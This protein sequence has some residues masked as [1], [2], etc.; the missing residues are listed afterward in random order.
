MKKFKIILIL[1]ILGLLYIKAISVNISFKKNGSFI[2]YSYIP[3]TINLHIKTE[4]K[5]SKLWCNGKSIEINNNKKHD[6]FYRGEEEV[7]LHLNMGENSCRGDYI[8]KNIKQKPNFIDFITISILIILPITL[9]LFNLLIYFLD[10]IDLDFKESKREI[11]SSPKLIFLIVFIGILIRIL[12]F[13]KY[14]IMLFQHDWHG[15][16]D[17]IKYLSQNYALPYMPNRGW[18]YP[19]Q[20]LYYIISAILYKI[21]LYIGYSSKEA[22]HYGVGSFALISSSL[23]LIFSAELLNYLTSKSWVKVVA[24]LFL[25]FTPSLVYMSARV[26]NDTLVLS[27]SVMALYFIVQSYREDF[28]KGFYPALTVTTLLF[29]TKLST[30]S[31]EL[32]LFTLLIITYIKRKAIKREL[33]IFSLIGVFILSWTLWHLYTPLN[34]GFYMVN[35]AKFPK[36]TIE[37][38]DSGYFLSFHISNLISQGYSFVFGDNSVRYSLPTYQYGTMFFG[39]FD[40]RYFLNRTPY[41]LD[42]MRAILISGLIYIVGLFSYIAHIKRENL[43]NRLIFGVVVINLILILKFIIS[44]PSICN[45]DF[46]YFVG[47]FTIIGYI[48]AQGLYYISNYHKYIKYIVNSFL[49][50]LIIGELIFFYSLYN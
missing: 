13:N 34:G 39:E 17:L 16:I 36:Q 46:R 45:S 12:Y 21:F 5:K 32:F 6:Y 35:S 8:D 47:S 44:Y 4:Y 50:L 37:H 29:L 23:F 33:L 25:S 43:L 49:L 42:I 30:A 3:Q 40:Y 26:N 7:T 11:Y 41:L 38:L 10:K 31:I 1:F 2:I 20:P 18:E 48:F 27:L 14:G 15:H 24:M 9:L 28:K 22:L 19:Q